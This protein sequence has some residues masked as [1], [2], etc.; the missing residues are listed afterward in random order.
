MSPSYED[1]SFTLVGAQPIYKDSRPHKI[2]KQSDSGPIVIP[3]KSGDLFYFYTG[4]LRTFAD[5]VA[6]LEE[7]MTTQRVLLL[8]G[9]R[10][11][12]PDDTKPQLRRKNARPGEPATLEETGTRWLPFDFDKVACPIDPAQDPRGASQWVVQNYLPTEFHHANYWTQFTT[13]TGLGAFDGKVSLRLIFLVCQSLTNAECKAYVKCKSIPADPSIYCCAHPIYVVEAPYD[14][15]IDPLSER[16][17]VVHQDTECVDLSAD[18][19][20]IRQG[21]ATKTRR[22]KAKA[23]KKERIAKAESALKQTRE[24]AKRRERAST[25][26]CP[27]RNRS[28]EPLAPTRTLSKAD[29]EERLAA[30]CSAIRNAKEGERHNI[31]NREAYCASLLCNTL[32]RKQVE[33]ALVAA[34]QTMATPKPLEEAE[35]EVSQALDDGAR[36]NDGELMLRRDGDG[37]P[38][39]CLEN[40][41]AILTYAPEWRDVIGFDERAQ[42]PVLLHDPPF[43]DD[44]E[45]PSARYPRPMEDVDVLRIRLMVERTYALRATAEIANSA[46]SVAAS[47]ASYDP[48]EVWLNALPAWDGVPRVDTAFIRLWGAPDTPYSRAVSRV[49][50]LC[51]VA[52]GT[53]PGCKVDIVVILEGAQGIGKSSSLLRLFPRQFVAEGLSPIG[54]KDSIMELVGVWVVELAELDA[55]NRREAAEAKAFLSRQKDN[56]RVPY[57]RLTSSIQRRVIFVGTTNETQYLLDSTGARR[58]LPLPV[59][60]VDAAGI[61][62]ERDQ[63]FAEALQRFRGLEQHWLTAQEEALAKAE[64]ESRYCPDP[65]ED[66]IEALLGRLDLHDYVTTSMIL[67]SLDVPKGQQSRAHSMRVAKV[68]Q[69]LGYAKAR[70]PSEFDKERPRG[71]FRDVGRPGVSRCTSMFS[72]I[73]EARAPEPKDRAE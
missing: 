67:N 53:E 57:G 3:Y 42:R 44:I 4:T 5:L 37:Q 22:S 46:I 63:L 33:S 40:F 8:R 28:A 58:Y 17:F 72:G 59:A 36:T 29:A 50:F 73:D 68:M 7:G 25:D 41:V 31:T 14:G 35:V 6:A 65:Y 48:V 12:D 47:A 54:T 70:V 18:I 34:T 52:R 55:L 1:S 39:A 16:T 9:A 30:H 26:S 21:A 24:R 69:R 62:A 23:A 11:L 19:L 45:S 60:K 51:A 71:W 49:F 64:Q 38:L 56:V 2:V 32:G 61:Q 27:R 43:D 13:S 20:V 15:M 66:F 10:V